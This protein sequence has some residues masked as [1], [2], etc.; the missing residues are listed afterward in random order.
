[1]TLELVIVGKIPYFNNR[2]F[3]ECQ[4]PAQEA[5]QSIHYNCIK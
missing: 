2:N 1:M 3:Q 5:I 4:V